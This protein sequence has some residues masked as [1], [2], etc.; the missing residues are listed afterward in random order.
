MKKY[1]FLITSFFTALVA[2]GAT[3]YVVPGGAG[4]KNGTSWANA[5][6]DVQTAIDKA[7]SD[8]GG[9]VWIAKG[10]YKHGSEMKMKNNVAI[11]GGFAG[12]ETSKDQR[13][14]GNH[15]ILDGEG[16][17][18]VFYNNYNNYTKSNPLTNSAKLDNVTIQNGYSSGSG[19]GMYNSY[20]S[21]EITNCTFTNNRA[22]ASGGGMFNWASSP[23]LTN[24][25]F[26]GN[27][28]YSSGSGMYNG[29]YS[30]PV[31]TN[32][33][34]TNNRA[35]SSG[36]GMC[37]GSY[38]SPTLTNCILWGNTASSSGNEIYNSSSNT[39][40]DTCIIEG[41]YS[42]YGTYTNIITSDPKLMPLGNYGG[43][44]QTC[45]VGAGSSAIDVGKVVYG[46]TTDARGF[47]R[48]VPY[49]IG[50]CQY[51]PT[52]ITSNL[53]DIT[54]WQ[55][56][57]VTLT[58]SIEGD[59]PTYQ[60]QYSEDGSTWYDIE[61][62]TSSTLT[63]SNVPSSQNGYK[64]RCAVDSDNSDLTY[65]SVAILTVKQSPTLD[66]NPTG[67]EVWSNVDRSLSVSATGEE[68]T[69]QWY[70]NGKAIEGATDSTLSFENMQ[71]SASG[72]YYCVIKNPAGSVQSSSA[73]VIVRQS[74][75]STTITKP[76]V[77]V[78][79]ASN[80]GYAEFVVGTSAYNPTY[81]WYYKL[82]TS[83]YWNK[84]SE[85][86]NKL[87]IANETSRRNAQIKCVISN[88]GGSAETIANLTY[89]NDAIV[90]A[91]QPESVHQYLYGSASF[92]VEATTSTEEIT[93]QWQKLSNGDWV[94]INGATNST[95]TDSYIQSSDLTSYRCKVGNGAN[96]FAYSNTATLDNNIV[97]SQQQ[98]ASQTL[99]ENHKFELSVESQCNNIGYQWQYSS[100]N[101]EWAN[102]ENATSNS[103]SIEA[104]KP[105][106]AG[107]YRCVISGNNWISTT[108]RVSQLAVKP[109]G[110]F[111]ENLTGFEVWSDTN[112]SLSVSATGEELTYQWYFNGEAIEGATESTL[113]FDN[114]QFDKTGSY[115]CVITNPAGSV[116]SSAAEVVVHQTARITK[117]LK[118]II[119]IKEI[120]Y[121]RFEIES[122]SYNPTFK[123][124]VDGQLLEDETENVLFIKA[125]TKTSV[126]VKCV[127]STDDGKSVESK[128]VRLNALDA[129]H[130]QAPLSITTHPAD[131]SPTAWGETSKFTISAKSSSS[132]LNY[133]WQGSSDGETWENLE[134]Q[135]GATCSVKME[136]YNK[137]CFVRCEINNGIGAYLYSNSAKVIH[138][139]TPTEQPSGEVWLFDGEFY[140]FELELGDEFSSGI[141]YDDG[142]TF[143]WQISN[144]SGSTWTNITSDDLHGDGFSGDPLNDDELEI[145]M[146][147][148]LDGK[149]YRCLYSTPTTKN[150]ETPAV[151]VRLAKDIEITKHPEIII[152]APLY[153]LATFTVEATGYQ[154]QY[155]WY[156]M[157]SSGEWVEM[158]G[159]TSATL[160]ILVDEDSPN[161]SYQ[162]CVYNRNSEAFSDDCLILMVDDSTP[163]P[164]GEW[165]SKSGLT[166]SNADKTATPH[167]DG[168]TNLEKFTFGLDAS[169]ATSYGAN[170]SFKHTS[171]ATGATLQFPVSVDA[172][173]VVNVKALK[174]VDLINWEETTVTDTGETSSDGKFKIYKATAPIGEEGKV[175]LKLKVEEK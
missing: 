79:T 57:D 121:A 40:I 56:T 44:V 26:S 149:M 112:Q 164:Y 155:Q 3:Y 81:T 9:E 118:N 70:F 23:I 20:A 78:I 156:V 35:S 83:S 88:A 53:E 93:Y 16:K 32:C 46:V 50:A 84:L 163:D 139:I 109:I 173:G 126:T 51:C 141:N 174:A 1:L 71:T 167:N 38:C 147:A 37:N 65:S 39:T 86:S 99:W 12:T 67:F 98:I 148:D 63:L 170:A 111:M 89:T 28:T 130:S 33:T 80:N 171:D 47:I 125:G 30:C 119:T 128:T 72:S 8:G 27:R 52:E 59:N 6:A 7:S 85:T 73:T 165:A 134:G 61:G 105:S 25:T 122:D 13:V 175:F 127:I 161:Y 19:A 24:C 90:F 69:Y 114:I 150:L 132:V 154:P 144:D 102:I 120:G 158:E 43:N 138:S 14:A 124:Y 62:E 129:T 100:D 31:L 76:L 159:E 45:P 142:V 133:Q 113:S 151:T 143:Q 91:T 66:N 162:C 42:S 104:V 49:T 157:D 10:T 107:Y 5:Y 101:I 116:Q 74:A 75:D 2:S 41:G 115:Y 97:I 77:D 68:I 48:S 153:S 11:Y 54:V 36:G 160:T 131:S 21:P 123:W 135:T 103:F 34:F 4:N 137:N 87:T 146:T 108:S 95:Y 169:K 140:E 17:Y 136:G 58:V 22:S 18:R 15:T 168:I 94:D 166:G 117:D 82:N 64:Y 60:W 29:Y 172:E 152:S 92:V 145:V 106:D 96:T 55:N 110:A